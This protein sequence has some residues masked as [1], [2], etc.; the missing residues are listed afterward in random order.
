M[1]RESSGGFDHGVYAAGWL[2]RRLLQWDQC[3]LGKGRVRMGLEWVACSRSVLGVYFPL[4]RPSYCAR[5][6]TLSL[7]FGLLCGVRIRCGGESLQRAECQNGAIG[8]AALALGGERGRKGGPRG[9]LAGTRWVEVAA[10]LSVGWSR[11]P[12]PGACACSRSRNFLGCR[13][14]A[15]HCQAFTALCSA[16]LARHSTR[17]RPTDNKDAAT[18]L[19]ACYCSPSSRP[20]LPNARDRGI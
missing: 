1:C 3:R 19:C 2:C 6:S 17:S 5:R 7:W 18:R 11:A 20:T 9:E 15:C 4:R 8:D 13:A 12:V 10:V 14:L 16:Y